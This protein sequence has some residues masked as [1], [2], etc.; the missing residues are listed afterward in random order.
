M[1]VVVVEGDEE[2]VTRVLRELGREREQER[3]A[4]VARVI[5]GRKH[6]RSLQ[7]LDKALEKAKR[8]AAEQKEDE[9][10]P[11]YERRTPKRSPKSHYTMV[12]KVA[13]RY[14]RHKWSRVEKRQLREFYRTPENHY[15]NGYMIPEKVVRFAKS[16]HRTPMAVSVA[17]ILFGLNRMRV[18]GDM[19]WKRGAGISRRQLPA[20]E[21]PVKTMVRR[22]ARMPFDIEAARKKVFRGAE[23]RQVPADAEWPAL[24]GV[25][26]SQDIVTSTF[27]LFTLGD[28]QREMTFSQDGY[29]YG[30][31]ETKVWDR[32]LL[33]V[34]KNAERI[35]RYL[36]V[37]NR[38]RLVIVGKARVLR[39]G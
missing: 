35:C 33:S 21:R 38:F 23:Q 17:V 8:R 22:K 5:H 12:E 26:V 6:R 4:T 19:V 16:L 7:R 1:K 30:I 2:E 11:R 32:F 36:N 37:P 28:R 14:G 3:A 31:F 10:K 15:S 29:T 13:P 27:K 9:E 34:M 18:R 39:Y 20:Q 24:E 25:E